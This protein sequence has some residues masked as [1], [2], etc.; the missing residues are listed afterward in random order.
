MIA[1]A[2]LIGSYVDESGTHDDRL[3]VAA[4]FV[5]EF[6]SCN[7]FTLAWDRQILGRYRIPFFHMKDF[8]NRHSKIFRH[9]DETER[10]R[11][12]DDIISLV[13]EHMMLGAIGSASQ[14]LYNKLTTPIFRSTYGT[15]YCFAVQMCVAA[16]R[17][18][19]EQKEEGLHHMNIMLEDGH[20]NAGQAID[21]L[22][23]LKDAIA[24]PEI[25]EGCVVVE[26]DD[27][28]RVPSGVKI[29]TISLGSK[30]ATATRDTFGLQAADILAYCISAEVRT[31]DKFAVAVLDKLE[32]RTPI[33]GYTYNDQELI[34]S[35]VADM[36]E[37]E[38]WRKQRRSEIYEL[39]K[40]LKRRNINVF[41]LPYGLQLD[42]SGA[43]PE[44]IAELWES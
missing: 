7:A 20:K 9:L 19:I 25:P 33:C 16:A 32:R 6:E 4:A 40:V 31:K 23:R 22:R 11:L 13:S 24:I 3:I 17:E 8:R 30:Q 39:K 2:M 27:P 18:W 43:S 14:R 35:L 12:L 10:S 37:D 29:G 5:G 15:S 34:P 28:L 44:D 36:D 26:E 21:L 41:E 1:K 38:K 42:A